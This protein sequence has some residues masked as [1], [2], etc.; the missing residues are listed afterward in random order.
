MELSGC[1]TPKISQ[2]LKEYL[3]EF[4]PDIILLVESRVSGF[5]ADRVIRSI[6]MLISHRV[7]ATGFSEGV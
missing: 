7:E 1:T 3:Q 6:R 4:D 5:K 2:I